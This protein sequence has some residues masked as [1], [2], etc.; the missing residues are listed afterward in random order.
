MVGVPMFTS[1]SAAISADPLA[2]LLSAVVLLVLL[3]RL[4]ERRISSRPP[5]DAPRW[6]VATGVLLGLGLLT[7]LGVGIFLPIALGVA[8]ARSRRGARDA[9]LIVATLGIVVLPWLVHQVTTYGWLDPLAIGRHAAVVVDQRRFAGLSP[10]WLARFLTVSFHS[11]WAQF[12]WMGIVAP[13]RLYWI[14]GGLAAVGGLGLLRR[15]HWLGQP[16]WLLLVATVCAAGI[17]FVGYNLSFE[18]FQ[19]RY[20]FTALV[21]IAMLLAAGW[22]GYIPRRWSAW[23]VALVGALLVGLNAYALVRVLVPG[24]APTG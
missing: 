24:F 17:A 6:A 13:D 22:S 1:V 2:N 9:A 11:F 8:I 14:W 23:G 21:P 4:R 15:R 16:A 3:R 20:L 5:P 19:G 18:Q 10:D 7:K 12:G